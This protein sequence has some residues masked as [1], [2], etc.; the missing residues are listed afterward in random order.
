MNKT[1]SIN[2]SGIIF[3]VE[4]EG[5]E[6][7]KSYLENI[8]AQFKN[9]DEADMV[10]EDVEL[11]IAEIFTE[12]SS[13]GPVT[14][15]DV[16]YVVAVMGEATAYAPD[17]DEDENEGD[18]G[19]RSSTEESSQ[20]RERNQLYR[21]VE[22]AQI[23]GVCAG[24][25]H[26]YQ[27]NVDIVRVLFVL[28]ALTTLL[29]LGIILYLVLVVVIPPATTTSDKLKMKGVP[30]TVENI[31]RELNNTG[32]KVKST[33]RKIS[34]HFQGDGK[35]S[36]HKLVRFI[37]TLVGIALIFMGLSLILSFLTFFVGGF[38]IVGSN[39]QG[40][41]LSLFDL[42]GIFFENNLVKTLAWTCVYV[43]KFSIILLLILTGVRLIWNLKSKSI[44]YFSIFLFVL[45][46]V[47]FISSIAIGIKTAL[48]F[49]ASAENKIEVG[50]LVTDTLEVHYI[51][52]RPVGTN[53]LYNPER[54]EVLRLEQNR[55][56]LRFEDMD[57]RTGEDSIT[58]I[59][60]TLKANGS[61]SV[62]AYEH[63]EHIKHNVFMEG[64]KLFVDLDYSFP[65]E[66]K[67][68]GQE[69]EIDIYKPKNV[70]IQT[71]INKELHSTRTYNG[72]EDDYEYHRHYGRGVHIREDKQ[73][74]KHEVN[75]NF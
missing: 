75:I 32:E 2:L 21:D 69:A 53:V 31:K 68:R 9:S 25:A 50:S 6:K 27:I 74:G 43:A 45:F 8:R 47:T 59:Y 24:L 10:L 28:F 12:R 54:D 37:L 7:L 17:E 13:G 40:E 19:R 48:Q 39:G 62:D 14:C 58:R 49:E 71:Y 52:E 65:A 44:R 5:Y 16:D 70:V 51:S 4:E 38:G 61:T 56:S 22:N 34:R 46:I 66:D 60:H 1:I 64:N 26:H 67:I 41:L 57:Y 55:I 42:S 33:G 3:Y 63:L 35:E 30:V 29:T 18:K 23:A 11:R 15:E 20:G 73:T 36:M 72:E